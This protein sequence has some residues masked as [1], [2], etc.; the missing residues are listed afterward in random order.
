MGVNSYEPTQRNLFYV[1]MMGGI[2]LIVRAI[3]N[4]APELK[5]IKIRE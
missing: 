5:R 3:D 2:Y 4:L 1:S